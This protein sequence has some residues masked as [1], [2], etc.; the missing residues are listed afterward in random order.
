[1]RLY[2]SMEIDKK[3]VLNIGGISSIKLAE[4]YDTPLLVL[5]EK[6]IRDNARKYV[7]LFNKYYP[8][9]RTIYA[10]K[11]FLNLSICKI[12]EQ[13][14][15]GLDVVSDGELYTA[16]KAGFPVDDIYFHG[17]NKT[18]SEISMAMDAGIA[19]FMVDNSQEAS[20]INN[21]A[22]KKNK[23]QRIILRV[24][25]GIEAHTHEFIQTGQIDSKFGV[26]IYGDQ[27]M[28]AIN[29]ILKLKM[30][31]LRG[32]HVHIG[33]QIFN[34]I[35]YVRAIDV[36]L[37]FMSE[38]RDETGYVLKELDLGG[39]L[40]ISYTENETSPG[41]YNYT[42][43]VAENLQEKCEKLDYPLPDIINEPGRSII[44]TAGT[45]LYT[46]GTIKNI[47]GIRKYLAIDGGM[48]DNIRPAL[49]GAEYE[50][51]LANRADEIGTELVTIAGK[52]CESGDILIHDIKLPRANCGDILAMSCTGAYS[53][54]MSSNY[55]GL[56]RPAVVLVNEGQSDLIIKRE[57]Y[58]DLIRNNL[59]PERL[60]EK[61]L[62]EASV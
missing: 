39:G 41:I 46:I 42:K 11:A 53:Y 57:S 49:Y 61:R 5:D 21:L 9:S 27:A 38:V 7:N 13:E 51:V 56:P 44:G 43:L 19:Y 54:A 16:L 62:K 18:A 10:S 52:C 3:G 12:I 37:D 22:I 4:K 48:S 55:N 2:G 35:S 25:P 26:S 45:T 50:A 29:D 23:I 20:I 1:L 59:I 24:T 17:N 28:N 40:G 30:L 31:D 14:G 58:E 60:K 8:R 47:P 33:S 6:E 34:L 36:M 15:L 32:L